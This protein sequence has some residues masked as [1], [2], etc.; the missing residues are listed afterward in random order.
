MRSRSLDVGDVAGGVAGG[1][2]LV[3]RLVVRL[4]VSFQADLARLRPAG[5]RADCLRF[6]HP[7]EAT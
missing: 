2:D 7:A 6:A 5:G 4:V 1:E 3:A